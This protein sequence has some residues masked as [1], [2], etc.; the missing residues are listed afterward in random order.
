M[1]HQ[2]EVQQSGDVVRLVDAEL[3]TWVLE[4][5]ALEAVPSGDG[6]VSEGMASTLVRS[7]AEAFPQLK[8][9]IGSSPGVVVRF[10]P[11]VERGL[12]NG[13]YQLMQTAGGS[14][15]VARSVASGQFVEHGTVVAGVGLA[16][17]AWPVLLAGGVAVA[18][19]M[20]HQRWLEEV[21]EG[22]EAGLARITQ[23]LVDDDHG[24]LD[25]AEQL[26]E[27]IGSSAMLGAVSPLLVAEVAEV[28][29]RVEAVYFSRRRYAAR[30]KETL[31][32][33]QLAAGMTKAGQPR[34]WTA[35]IARDLI[36]GDQGV[37]DELALFF[38]AMIARARLGA[39]AAS[40]VIADGAYDVALRMLH[41][42]KATMRTD[43]WDLQRRLDA[44][45]N[46]EPEPG[47]LQKVP[48]L[49]VPSRGMT[50]R[51]KVRALSGGSGAVI[52]R[53]LLDDEPALELVATSLEV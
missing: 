41:Q 4:A 14:K 1:D 16:G 18:A 35:E 23:R 46:N 10:S 7:L 34:T 20:A 52:G 49:K 6:G 25:A 43:Y 5:V 27:L 26:I 31:E 48:G 30:F 42:T 21:F 50:A 9:V 24:E 39:I 15:T 38:R 40:M 36:D 13:T 12:R 47:V 8:A 2:I 51:E 53:R 29:R 3:G 37:I 32:A 44:L 33:R 19:S 45:A 11:Q 28:R 17:A 22:L